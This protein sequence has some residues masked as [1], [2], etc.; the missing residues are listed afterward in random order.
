MSRGKKGALI[1][2]AIL[3]VL[4]I[5]QAGTLTGTV[6]NWIILGLVVVHTLEVV[7]FYKLCRDAGGSL[8]GHLLN[9]FV[10]GYF[11]T[12]ELKAGSV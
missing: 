10:F 11:H 7:V 8:P 5:T 4:A 12:Q 2:Y 3:A 1:F 9:V 6:A